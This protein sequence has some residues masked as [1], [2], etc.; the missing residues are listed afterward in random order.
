MAEDETKED[1]EVEGHVFP[2]PFT[3]PL[4]DAEDEDGDDVEAHVLPVGLT[5]P[6]ASEDAEHVQ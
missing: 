5:V 2:T 6:A 4:K 1:P 3:L